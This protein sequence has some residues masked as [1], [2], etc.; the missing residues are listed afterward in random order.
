MRIEIQGSIPTSEN[1]QKSE[2][3]NGVIKQ[4]S[5][6]F[7][8]STPLTQTGVIDYGRDIIPNEPVQLTNEY[9]QIE[10]AMKSELSETQQQILDQFGEG[11][12]IPGFELVR[13]FGGDFL[14]QSQ[15][16]VMNRT[17]RELNNLLRPKGKELV[18]EGTNSNPLW[19]LRDFDVAQL[20][21]YQAYQKLLATKC[22]QKDE[23]DQKETIESHETEKENVVV[24]VT[25]FDREKQKKERVENL[26]KRIPTIME[27]IQKAVAKH[28]DSNSQMYYPVQAQT[29]F[30]YSRSDMLRILDTGIVKP[31]RGPDHHDYLT[32]FEAIMVLLT[33]KHYG[34]LPKNMKKTVEELV[35]TELDKAQFTRSIGK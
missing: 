35:N 5:D 6:F 29:V 23:P 8:Q 32:P 17:I 21:S 25:E 3:R 24:N 7:S 13:R 4:N 9:E 11:E 12:M 27:D 1:T 22:L 18:N 28:M 34:T 2:T 31:S 30:G 33:K 19:E 16:F 20:E 14:D 10:S 15:I 26:Q